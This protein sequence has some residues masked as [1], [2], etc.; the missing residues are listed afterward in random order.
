MNK[1]GYFKRKS[2]D[3][4]ITTVQ[5]FPTTKDGNYDFK[6]RRICNVSEPLDK[7]DVTNKDYIDKLLVN[8][9]IENRDHLNVFKE[10]V[11][12]HFNLVKKAFNDFSNTVTPK[13]RKSEILW[14]KAVPI[15]PFISRNLGLDSGVLDNSQLFLKGEI[16]LP[17][18]TRK[19]SFA[20]STD[21]FIKCAT[22]NIGSRKHVEGI[23]RVYV[24][25]RTALAPTF[26]SFKISNSEIK[27][28]YPFE[29]LSKELTFFFD[30]CHALGNDF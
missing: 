27:I 10:Q 17:E 25:N 2:V 9:S 7:T 1:F 4:N 3:S 18:N 16:G 28:N 19:T 21:N 8:I 23:C 22:V 5:S 12:G 11:D 26:H 30:S 20:H 24:L 29:L 13:L 14:S 15:S 6:K